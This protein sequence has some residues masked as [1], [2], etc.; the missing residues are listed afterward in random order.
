MI[1]VGELF[2]GGLIGFLRDP[3]W[4]APSGLRDPIVIS[5]SGQH[6][7]CWYNA[8]ATGTFGGG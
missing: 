1:E 5:Q 8:T 3:G 2:E 4:E 6:S 7:Y